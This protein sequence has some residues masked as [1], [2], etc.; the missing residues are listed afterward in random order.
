MLYF[1]AACCIIILIYI[2]GYNIGYSD[3]LI[4][5]IDSY[6]KTIKAVLQ[7]IIVNEEG[8]DEN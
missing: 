1:I 2:L 6:D 8:Q 7:W 3:G 5:G 4:A